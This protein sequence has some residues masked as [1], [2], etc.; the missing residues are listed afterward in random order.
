MCSVLHVILWIFVFVNA[1]IFQSILYI[2]IVV[3]WKIVKHLLLNLQKQKN[4]WIRIDID[5]CESIGLQTKE[6]DIERQKYEE[7]GF[8]YVKWCCIGQKKQTRDRKLKQ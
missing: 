7:N 4:I 8:R 6:S 3:Y 1:G 5:V 2:E